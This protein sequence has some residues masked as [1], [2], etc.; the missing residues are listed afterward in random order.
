[1][2]TNFEVDAVV[3]I[4]HGS[5]YK[6]EVDKASGLLTVDRPL[7]RPLPYNY[8]YIPNTLHGDGDP[9]DVC[10]VGCNSIQPLAKV[11]VILRGVLK[12][13]DNGFSD[14][15]LIATVVGEEIN[16]L[17]IWSHVDVVKD[18]LSTYKKGFVVGKFEDVAEAYSI[19]MKDVESYLHG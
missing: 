17:D 9:L 12:C 3:E 1:M 8:G 2:T 6:Y 4:P 5:M 10:I 19:L 13:L 16:D 7:P 15:K 11:K 14:D 18:Y